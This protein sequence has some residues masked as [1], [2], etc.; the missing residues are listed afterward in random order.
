MKETNGFTLV[1]LLIVVAIIGI[2]GA[3]AIPSYIGIQEKVRKGAVIRAASSNIPEL[4][5]WINAVKKA[6]TSL[7]NLIEVDSNGDGF[8]APPDLNNTELA[9]SGIVTTFV[10]SKQDLSP[11]NSSLPLWTNGGVANNQSACD[12]I[13]SNNVGQI[14]LCYTPD[15]NQLIR[16]IFISVADFNGNIIY[17][18]IVSAD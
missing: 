12:S 14:T 17:Q 6:G 10:A 7:G 15:E 16:F 13:A 8:I 5:G 2:L 1:E 4:Q 9:S 11:W 18:K 3:I